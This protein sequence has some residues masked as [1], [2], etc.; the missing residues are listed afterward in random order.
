[1]E[2]SKK[3]LQVRLSDY[4]QQ[5][6]EEMA[7]RYGMTL[8]SLVAYIVGS[9]LDAN[10]DMKDRANRVLKESSEEIAQTILADPKMIQVMMEIFSGAEALPIQGSKE[11]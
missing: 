10:Y 9:W 7:E 2:N 6:I 5:R 8:N 4:N 1:M 11:S 3:K